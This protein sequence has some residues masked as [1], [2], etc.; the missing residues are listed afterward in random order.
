MI[1]WAELVVAAL[2]ELDAGREMVPGAKLRQRMEV[3][4]AKAGFDVG[5]HLAE[6]AEPF[7]LSVSRVSEVVVAR[8]PGS[9]V[10]VGITGAS[11]PVSVPRSTHYGPPG[12]LRK[13]VFLAFTRVAPVPFVY[14]PD[15]DVF[16]PQDRATEPTI[17]VERVSLDGLIE[18]RMAFVNSLPEED[19]SPL[20]DAL[21]RSPNPLTTFREEAAAHGLL[22]QWASRQTEMIKARVVSWAQAHGI[23]PRET[24]F[25][26]RT[27]ISAHQALERL[28]PYITP[29]E[30]RAMSVPFRAV[31]AF[32]RDESR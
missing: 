27:E 14:M 26:Q 4:G 21:E 19:R 25:Q 23:S 11:V 5:A 8:R 6:S 29:D 9:D 20:R 24:W 2:R 22:G 12:T 30:I 3:L 17:E 10:L 16:T 28:L 15:A 31:E 32:L 7:V 18:D 1:E 13:D